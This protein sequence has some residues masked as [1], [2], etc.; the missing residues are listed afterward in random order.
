MY[1]PVQWAKTT[2]S[3]R[4]NEAD[5][6][7]LLNFFAARSASPEEAKV[8]ILL[9]SVPGFDDLG[10]VRGVADVMDVADRK[11]IGLLASDSPLYGHEIYALLNNYLV[12]YDSESL[13]T[14]TS[15]SELLTSED[16][17][18]F[19][20]DIPLS[21]ARMA[22][23]GRRVLWTKDDEVFAYDRN[24]EELVVITAP[25]PEDPFDISN[26]EAWVD[27]E[28]IDGYFILG[29]KGGQIF[30]SQ[31]YSVQFDDLDFARANSKHDGIVALE[32]IN[33]QLFVFGTDSIE[34]WYNAG[35]ADFAF[36]RDNSFNFNIGAAA[37]DTVQTNQG[38]I[39]FLG[40]DLSVYSLINGTRLTRISN[41]IVDYD[42]GQSDPKKARAFVYTEEGHKFYSLT[43]I[44]ADGTP[45]VNWTFDWTTGLWHERSTTN[46]LCQT[47]ID[48]V[49][50]VG[51]DDSLSL[52][53][54]HLD[55]GLDTAGVALER[56]AISPIIYGG[57]RRLRHYEFQIDVSY[58]QADAE[59]GEVI[60][61]FSDDGKA[62]WVEREEK[63]VSQ[64]SRLK[65]NQL[66]SIKSAGRHLRLQSSSPGRVTINGAY[67]NI[68]GLSS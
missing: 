54:M 7:R 1:R 26:S 40:S 11:V 57:Q 39:T 52:F 14:G 48:G 33:R 65:W 13:K 41:E 6:S 60:F 37:R 3:G 62:T 56:E 16:M 18:S 64:L 21:P 29:S 38:A 28:W 19:T 10:Y 66:G 53:K 67:A 45:R 44:N 42:I 2:V 17:E 51:T 5:G 36:R 30:H 20:P 31:L 32:T 43:L 9:Y 24:T 25:V 68:E 4:Q 58:K 22:S 50:I 61:A 27:I 55:T 59:S 12:R 23:D 49:N 47:E 35:A 15:V 34:R 63:T 46:I 8:P